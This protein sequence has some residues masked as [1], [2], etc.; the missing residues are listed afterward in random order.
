M[1]NWLLA[2][3]K[4]IGTTWAQTLARSLV[5][6]FIV[7]VIGSAAACARMQDSAP[8]IEPAN[9]ADTNTRSVVVTVRTVLSVDDVTPSTE[10][11]RKLVDKHD[12]IIANAGINGTADDRVADFEVRIPADKLEAFRAELNGVG[13]VDSE[14]EQVEDVTAPHADLEARLRNAQ[15]HE[16]RLLS[17]LEEKTGSLADVVAIEKELASVRENIE[18]MD[19]EKRVMDRRIAFATVHISLRP[20]HTNLWAHPVD[21]IA[22]AFETGLRGARNLVVGSAIVAAA[23]LP[24]L[25]V[26][27]FAAGLMFLF[28][29]ALLRRRSRRAA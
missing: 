11:V 23:V 22:S 27:A 24:S 21:A 29:R 13:E 7:A 1:G 3:N 4:T 14:S 26:I 17:L 8:T 28:V 25:L 16:K 9:S 12:G 19:A 20:T 5:V 6:L 18:R 15:A 10:K 2:S